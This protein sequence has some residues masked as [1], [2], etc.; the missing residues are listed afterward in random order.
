M[1]REQIRQLLHSG[2]LQRLNLISWKQSY[3]NC[4]YEA[5]QLK[6][7]MEA[8]RPVV[9]FDRYLRENE[10]LIAKVLTPKMKAKYD[11]LIKVE[12]EIKPKE[13][14]MGLWN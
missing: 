4:E 8:Q 12:I 10:F 5:N 11:K 13:K 1:N 9:L 7:F 3:I 6:N 14:Q 2:A